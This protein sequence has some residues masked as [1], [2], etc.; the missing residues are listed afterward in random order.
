MFVSGLNL[1]NCLDLAV[2]DFSA[3]WC[4]RAV[5]W[6]VQR[7]CFLF[8]SSNMGKAWCNR[9]RT[10]FVPMVQ[11]SVLLAY[12]GA[13]TLSINR[14]AV[15]QRNNITYKMQLMNSVFSFYQKQNQHCRRMWFCPNTSARCS[16]ADFLSVPCKQPINPHMR[17]IIDRQ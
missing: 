7:S 12:N 9:A 8:I 4:N 11:R 17:S 6:P 3:S 1:V 2:A 16:P 5:Q 14:R 13:I 10:C 15:L